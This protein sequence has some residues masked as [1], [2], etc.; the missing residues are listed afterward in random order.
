MSVNNYLTTPCNHPKYH[1]LHQ[2]HGGSLKSRIKYFVLQ[3]FTYYGCGDGG[4]GGGMILGSN[5]HQ[6]SSSRFWGTHTLVQAHA[7]LARLH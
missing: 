1:S 2:H 3:N 5:R 7:K 4:G 6:E